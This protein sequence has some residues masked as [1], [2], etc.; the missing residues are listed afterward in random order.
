MDLIFNEVKNTIRWNGQYNFFTT[1]TNQKAILTKK[2]GNSAEV[3]LL[4]LGLLQQAGI[5]SYPV[6]IS[7]R[8][9]GKHPGYP[10]LS[11][12]NHVIVAAESGNKRY[13]MD[14]TDRNNSIGLLSIEDLNHK[15]LRLDLSSETAAWITLEPAGMSQISIS[16]ILKMDNDGLLTGQLLISSNQYAGKTRRD[17]CTEISNQQELIKNYITNKPDY[18][19]RNT[20]RIILMSSPNHLMKYWISVSKTT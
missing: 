2:S 4:L 10:V 6:L 19:P 13:L 1:E 15:G 16:Y 18:L 14:A 20:V 17:L 11:T 5:K 7:T 8:K 9:N 12:F 3:N